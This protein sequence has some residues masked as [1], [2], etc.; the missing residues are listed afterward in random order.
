M[1][2][3]RDT[4]QI[5]KNSQYVYRTYPNFQKAVD[6]GQTDWEAV[7]SPKT[8]NSKTGPPDEPSV[9]APSLEGLGFSTIPDKQFVSSQGS[10]S[11]SECEN[12]AKIAKQS[13][14]R[15]DPVMK[16]LEDGTVGVDCGNQGSVRKSRHWN[17]SD[18]HDKSSI[19]LPRET[20]RKST[21]GSSKKLGRP[22]KQNGPTDLKEAR[23][24]AKAM[25]TEDHDEPSQPELEEPVS[26]SGSKRKIYETNNVEEQPGP[27]CQ[28][29]AKS[30]KRKS[31]ETS[32]I[33]GEP[34]PKRRYQA[35]HAR[36]RSQEIGQLGEP[37]SEH[38]PL[39]EQSYLNEDEAQKTS[40]ETQTG[41]ESCR[42]S[43]R[44]RK[45][46]RKYQSESAPSPEPS[47]AEQSDDSN[48]KVR[49][50]P[51]GSERPRKKYGRGRPPKS[52]VIVIKFDRLLQADWLQS[53]NSQ[54]M[55]SAPSAEDP[56][57][58][59]DGLGLTP[60][61]L[62]R[63]RDIDIPA[64][65]SKNTTKDADV[66]EVFYDVAPTETSE[67]I[68]GPE[69]SNSA[70]TPS[71][72]AT[73]DPPSVEQTD[74]FE[75]TYA[76]KAISDHN[77]DGETFFDLQ[78]Q[79]SPSS[80]TASGENLGRTDLLATF[81]HPTPNQNTSMPSLSRQPTVEND[82]E[83]SQ[84]LSTNGGNDGHP[85]VLYQTKSVSPV[86]EMNREN[87]QQ[88]VGHA[89]EIQTSGFTNSY[90]K[91]GVAISGG[92][93]GLSRAKTIIQVIKQAGGVFP[94]GNAI[95][96]PFVTAWGENRSGSQLDRKTLNR[97]IKNLIDQDKLRKVTFI[98]KDEK[99][100]IVTRYVL[101]LPDED[102]TSEKVREIQKRIS[103]AHPFHF[104]PP[105]VEVSD[106]L[107][108]G[109]K[110]TLRGSFEPSV[111]DNVSSR[112]H[113][114]A[115][116][117]LGNALVSI[118]RDTGESADVA[119]PDADTQAMQRDAG[120]AGNHINASKSLM[121][122]PFISPT[123]RFQ[124]DDSIIVHRLNEPKGSKPA[125]TVETRKPISNR[126]RKSTKGPK[127]GRT[128]PSTPARSSLPTNSSALYR[129]ALDRLH[130]RQ[131]NSPKTTL[132][133]EQDT[134][135][136]QKSPLAETL[137]FINKSPATYDPNY[138]KSNQL[139]I[140]DPDQNFYASSGT[141]STESNVT[142]NARLDLWR[143]S[144]IQEAF[145][146]DMP[147][148]IQDMVPRGTRRSK[149]AKPVEGRN[150]SAYDQLKQELLQIRKW[151]ESVILDKEWQHNY[152]DRK[153]RAVR[154]INHNMPHGQVIRNPGQVVVDC[155][156]EG[157]ENY[158]SENFL[159][160]LANKHDDHLGFNPNF[161]PLSGPRSW[162]SAGSAPIE[163][164]STSQ[165]FPSL[166]PASASEQGHPSP[167]Q[168]NRPKPPTQALHGTWGVLVPQPRAKDLVPKP[169]SPKHTENSM[170][171]R[172]ARGQRK[173]VS[174]RTSLS[175]SHTSPP[176][177]SAVAITQERSAALDSVEKKSLQLAVAIVR[178][179]TSGIDQQEVQWGLVA[180]ACNYMRDGLT[181]KKCWTSYRQK[182]RTVADELQ[183][184]FQIRFAQAYE[185]GDLP[186][187]DYS[188]LEDF[189][190]AWLLHWARTACAAEYKPDTESEPLQQLPREGRRALKSSD[191]ISAFKEE[192]P[193]NER[194]FSTTASAPY[195][196]ALVNRSMFLSPIDG[197]DKADSTGA[198]TLPKHMPVSDLEVAR[199]WIRAN[200]LTPH[201]S[202]NGQYASEKLRKLT[203]E[204]IRTALDD[205]MAKKTLRHVKKNRVLPGRNYDLTETFLFS[206]RRPL[207]IKH[208]REAAQYKQKLDSAFQ[209]HNAGDTGDA[210]SPNLAPSVMVSGMAG[211]GEVLG[212]LNLVASRH[213][214]VVAHVPPITA[215]I[216]S[217]PEPQLSKWGLTAPGYQTAQ[218]D[219]KK[220]IFDLEV[221]PTR[222]YV[223]GNPI[224]DRLVEETIR[225]PP[226][227]DT[228]DEKAPIPLWLD[229]NG[230][231]LVEVWNMVLVAILTTLVSR[232]GADL[233][234]ISHCCKRNLERWE[235]LW[236]L[237][238]C[239]AVGAARRCGSGWTTS[240][241]WWLVITDGVGET[242]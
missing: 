105:G 226:V 55:V 209:G 93:I 139:S 28:R 197:N 143:S 167:Q 100:A 117:A 136:N 61:E 214:E 75:V 98:F 5:A 13:L 133:P 201:A 192:P 36:D 14:S 101:T 38:S 121:G 32:N 120:Q 79:L 160:S 86:R 165:S 50:N 47:L 188:K 44:K 207:D 237:E 78:S 54:S 106:E 175:Q 89:T 235:A 161:S 153:L 227:P 124:T 110:R 119:L 8:A 181:L 238:W 69:P 2:V 34:S 68:P 149:K 62:D 212:V 130:H 49:I 74:S 200:C 59:G 150:I 42:R 107:K 43:G 157:S 25:A 156:N 220:L 91:R 40:A 83:S 128:L 18:I 204:T 37:N 203:E 164:A 173:N 71:S 166:S 88:D 30:S 210:F 33:E 23:A 202:F 141:F 20:S 3:I 102:P 41:Q 48:S 84:N 52:L 127:Q 46:K 208:F 6:A 72:Y 170:P 35:N 99:G 144:N 233:N 190:W 147:Y 132:R 26:L 111:T 191:N 213:L 115:N 4:V 232:P 186:E 108:K 114:R 19:V 66:L 112:V 187:L 152:G 80:P 222:T 125:S 230:D 131:T 171:T 154:F 180:Q 9:A 70:E 137:S 53:S 116:A 217:A 22:R 223:Y 185:K 109:M 178:S 215:D 219:R 189:D 198:P 239:E 21:R 142:R 182:A 17:Q 82:P 228:A 104:I 231:C 163:P 97:A 29:L 218:M 225:T 159:S 134:S 77:S 240:D 135:T 65:H 64:K 87:N 229:I 151:E 241:W 174:R 11:L 162:H 184:R 12:R 15:T 81:E 85:G 155:D 96:Y 113:L 58:Y 242:A 123:A 193:L 24:K 169:A 76:T 56:G 129:R 63:E 195:R 221:R 179:L 67:L 216:N 148:G 92:F 140:M 45:R 51:P 73:P 211:D 90:R 234:T 183:D 205:M 31:H 10:A 206:F 103:D 95:W 7:I 118:N 194:F 94:G 168:P 39:T 16:I 224:K 126:A 158:T 27:K 177:D 199:S 176:E 172:R 1:A 146:D 122:N 60:M 236:C 138:E 196:D 57:S 145:E